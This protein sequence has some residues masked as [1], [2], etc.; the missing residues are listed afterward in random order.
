MGNETLKLPFYEFEMIDISTDICEVVK[1]NPLNYN[2]FKCQFSLTRKQ[3]RLLFKIKSNI[4]YRNED[5]LD[6]WYLYKSIGEYNVFLLDSCD[7]EDVKSICVQMIY[8][9]IVRHSHCIYIDYRVKIR[10]FDFKSLSKCINI[11]SIKRYLN[12]VKDYSLC[13]NFESEEFCI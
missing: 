11:N 4:Y 5:R 6:K 9:H 10:M 7:E 13:S 8:Q 3:C 1:G 12:K 2:P